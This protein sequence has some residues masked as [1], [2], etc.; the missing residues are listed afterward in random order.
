[1]SRRILSILFNLA[2]AILFVPTAWISYV[3]ISKIIGLR[4]QPV[5]VAGTGSMYPS[6]FW[7]ETQGGP[8]KSNTEGVLEYRSS[9][10][11]YRY[12]SGINISQQ[13][14][15]KTT[16][17]YGDMV[18]FSSNKTR[19]I[20]EKEGKNPNLGFIKRII[21]KA[22]DTI[23]LRD[24]YVLRN[25]KIIEEPYITSPRSTYA[26]T[27]LAECT[28]VTVPPNSYFVLG[29]NR[30]VSSDSRFE[31]SFV[32][33]DNIQFYLPLSKQGIYHSLWRDTKNDASL[34]GTPTLSSAEFY[35]K[36]TNLKRNQKLENSAKARGSALL[37]NTDTNYKMDKAIKDAGYK[38]IVTGE[39]VMFGHYTAEELYSAIQSNFETKA[40]L[41]NP[42]Y[43]DIGISTVISDVSGCPTQVIV[44][45]LG[46]YIPATYEPGMKEN[47]ESAKANLE[48]VI[49]SW[50]KAIGVTGVDQD[51][52]NELLTLLKTKKA[53]VDDVL[54]VINKRE[55]MSDEIEA[56]LKQ[57]EAN[58]QRASALAKELSGQ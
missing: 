39:F 38:N 9:P 41:S 12:F 16:L 33:E 10:R 14:Y 29:D 25:G 48:E 37:K 58:S 57:D 4:P 13:K 2:L 23:E 24:G 32:L 19:E 46:G 6:L 21:G 34:S 22:G 3:E 51:K 45:H 47:W 20:L 43:D 28:K 56:R 44:G 35:Q 11:M 7:D 49:P 30:K 53:L 52:L 5:E 50:E 15:L 36:V 18:A 54:S 55:W 8:E 42:D 31:L 17:D 26:G 27:S 1:M 40:Q